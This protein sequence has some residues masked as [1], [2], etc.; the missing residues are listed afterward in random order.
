MG[1][2]GSV[3]LFSLDK[4]ISV[5][6]L[7][8]NECLAMG[9]KKQNKE[10]LKQYFANIKRR[11]VIVSV[12]DI[13]EICGQSLYRTAKTDT[14]WWKKPRNSLRECWESSGYIVVS[15]EANDGTILIT[16]RQKNSKLV[17][18]IA[19]IILSLLLFV[20]FAVIGFRLEFPR[21]TVY[22][23]AT[24]EPLTSGENFYETLT[25]SFD[26]KGDSFRAISA[27]VF[28]SENGLTFIVNEQT[29]YG[30]C[31]RIDP[32]TLSTKQFDDGPNHF[33][34]SALDT[35]VIDISSPVLLA[36]LPDYTSDFGLSGIGAAS[37]VAQTDKG[38]KLV[39]ESSKLL[40]KNDGH[41]FFYIYENV[42]PSDFLVTSTEFINKPLSNKSL[43][44]LQEARLSDEELMG[45]H[46]VG[47]SQLLDILVDEYEYAISEY[48][49]NSLYYVMES[50]EG[51][52]TVSFTANGAGIESDTYYSDLVPFDYGDNI[53]PYY[54]FADNSKEHSFEI[55]I[56]GTNNS[57]GFR[58]LLYSEVGKLGTLKVSANGSIE[59]SR[60]IKEYGANQTIWIDFLGPAIELSVSGASEIHSS[61]SYLMPYA[62]ELRLADAK[63][64]YEW[65]TIDA[66]YTDVVG[67]GRVIIERGDLRVE[68]KFQNQRIQISAASPIGFAIKETW[69]DG[70]T[71]ITVDGEINDMRI[72]E[73]T[74][75]PDFY[76]WLERHSLWGFLT[77][78]T[79]ALL[80]AGAAIALSR[81]LI[82]IEKLSAPR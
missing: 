38:Y 3:A 71:S 7:G 50:F 24:L 45:L 18:K 67:T 78:L 80:S 1:Y 27:E 22:L 46:S 23:E 28:P 55:S 16:Y 5:V 2:Y 61:D 11:K 17:I 40:E 37:R 12:E 75:V 21:V 43:D 39:W 33:D 20:L 65:D 76:E 70:G 26:V 44:K 30:G 34:F 49:E 6:K 73:T 31:V 29:G 32:D 8:G 47:N 81:L 68:H 63:V 15:T 51:Y 9:M 42:N 10:K 19:C 64:T 57:R 56:E 82:K 66:G 58:L 74:V 60:N 69:I 13:E 36:I 52:G 48:H 53:F 62:E 35:I 25:S 4:D 59:N 41:R 72:D 77:L 14:E 54:R 79:S